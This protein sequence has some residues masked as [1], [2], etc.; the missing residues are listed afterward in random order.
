MGSRRRSRHAHLHKVT[1][2][3]SNQSRLSI[4]VVAKAAPWPLFGLLHRAPLHWIAMHVAQLLHSL[5]LGPHVEVIEARLA[6]GPCLGGRSGLG[7]PPAPCKKRKERGTPEPLFDR[8][9]CPGPHVRVRLFALTWAALPPILGIHKPIP[10]SEFPQF[11]AGCS[12]LVKP[13]QVWGAPLLAVFARGGRRMESR[14][15]W[16]HAHPHNVTIIHS[17][18]PRLSILVVTKAAPWPLLGL[19]HQSPLHWIAMHVAQLLHSLVLRS[20]R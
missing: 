8:V 12:C 11:L 7:G 18:Q 2:I 5:V 13:D 1:I 16:P 14:R 10:V 4:F 6:G 20:T 17:D 3:H 19:L 15:R 9:W